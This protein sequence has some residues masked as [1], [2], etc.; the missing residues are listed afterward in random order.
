MMVKEAIVPSGSVPP[1]P[2]TRALVL[3]GMLKLAFVATG[4]WLGVGVGAGVGVGTGAG[5]GVGT[6]AGV[7]VG[8]GAGVG[9]GTGAATVAT[10]AVAGLI[11]PP[12]SVA[13]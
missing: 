1:N 13:L 9:V 11:A 8:T 3:G 10:V 6:G 5:V 12:L 4:G 2:G 7:G